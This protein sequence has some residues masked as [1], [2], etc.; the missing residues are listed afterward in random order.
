[1]K[2]DARVPMPTAARSLTTTPVTTRTA[3]ARSSPTRV[4][5][6]PSPSRVLQFSRAPAQ[7]SLFQRSGLTR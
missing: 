5:A 2:H 4:V 6:A 7:L 1:M 3:P